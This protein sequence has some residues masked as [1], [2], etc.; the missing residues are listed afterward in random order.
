MK[1]AAR[2]QLVQ[3]LKDVAGPESARGSADLSFFG[4]TFL[5]MRHASHSSKP[6]MPA[7]P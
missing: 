5:L 1:Q 3:R 4:P 7:A 6:G 2:K